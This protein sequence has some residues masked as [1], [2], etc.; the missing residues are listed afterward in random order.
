MNPPQKRFAKGIMHR[1]MTRDPAQAVE[2][3]RLYF[4]DEMAFATFLIA[5]MTTMA[6]AI[7]DHVQG[8]WLK[9]RLEPI[10]NFLCHGHFFL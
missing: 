1:T 2:P 5:G 9:R 10:M 4:N 7:V 6:L 8:A 3:I